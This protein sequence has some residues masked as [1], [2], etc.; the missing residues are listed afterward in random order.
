MFRA[1]LLDVVVVAVRYFRYRE[2]PSRVEDCRGGL[3]SPAGFHLRSM[4]CSA[5]YA[6]QC[7]GKKRISVCRVLASWLEQ[8]ESHVEVLAKRVVEI[9]T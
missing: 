7:E 6:A 2:K 4:I 9:K 5:E 3:I 1:K 8:S